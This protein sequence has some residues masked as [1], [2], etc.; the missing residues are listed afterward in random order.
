MYHSIKLL[1]ATITLGLIL[2]GCGSSTA[3]IKTGD[4]VN[5]QVEATKDVSSAI[6]VENVKKNL[7]QKMSSKGI[8]QANE[9]TIVILKLSNFRVQPLNSN[10]TSFST[11][12]GSGPMALLNS[13]VTTAENLNNVTDKLQ[14]K[15]SGVVDYSLQDSKK[16][17]IK[18]SITTNSTLESVGIDM[19]K[20]IP[21]TVDLFVDK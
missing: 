13:I 18:A 4:K 19:E 20:F 10:T 6:N 1:A 5:L 14:Q 7:L 2:T 3:V 21:H 12:F 15:V 11:G 8:S 17:H 16:E 9:G